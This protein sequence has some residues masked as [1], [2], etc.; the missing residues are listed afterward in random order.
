MIKNIIG[1]LIIIGGI[2]LGI[3]LGIWWCFI[4]GIVELINAA[5]ATPVDAVEIAYGIAKILFATAIMWITIAFSVF[6]GA[7]FLNKPSYRSRW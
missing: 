7:L 4:G 6:I 2:I 1:C 3:Y 5:K